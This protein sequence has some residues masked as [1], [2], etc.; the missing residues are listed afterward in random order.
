MLCLPCAV[1]DANGGFERA[2]RAAHTAASAAAVGLLSHVPS[3]GSTSSPLTA[4]RTLQQVQCLSPVAFAHKATPWALQNAKTA[5]LFQVR[6]C[7]S[8]SIDKAKTLISSEGGS[9]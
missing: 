1:F 6:C 3:G 8:S 9:P 7:F 5:L 4:L 2:I